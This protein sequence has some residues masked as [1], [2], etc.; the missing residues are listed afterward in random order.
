MSNPED[1][2]SII[3][4]QEV[5]SNETVAQQR[6]DATAVLHD[7]GNLLTHMGVSVGLLRRQWN[8]GNAMETFRTFVNNAENKPDLLVQTIEAGPDRLTTYL[9]AILSRMELDQADA[10]AQMGQVS[11]TVD[12]VRDIIR[13]QQGRARNADFA[14]LTDVGGVCDDVLAM[15][16]QL[17]AER[18]VTLKRSGPRSLAMI[19]D[20][21][22]LVRILTNLVSNGIDAVSEVPTHRRSVEIS[23]HTREHGVRITVTDQGVGID[24]ANLDHIVEKGFTTKPD[25]HGFGLA[26]CERAASEMGGEMRFTSEGVDRG[27]SFH[28]NL[29]W[30]PPVR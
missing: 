23:V 7:V 9:R 30:K 27:A 29:P 3:E 11:S 14:K 21:T 16:E 18:N 22:R 6:D 24:Y 15:L 5:T 2:T 13:A 10:D 26:A 20:R 1:T 4:L 8:S 28:L 19:V 12:Q 25:G 17:A